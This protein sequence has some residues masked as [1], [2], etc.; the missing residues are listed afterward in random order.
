[1]LYQAKRGFERDRAGMSKLLHNLLTR[2]IRLSIQCSKKVQD[3]TLRSIH[4]AAVS[5]L[6]L[7]FS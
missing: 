7:S 4:I 3:S 6:A 2:F 5:K 1:V